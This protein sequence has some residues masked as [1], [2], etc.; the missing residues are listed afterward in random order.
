[1]SEKENLAPDEA[2]KGQIIG[3]MRK[4]KL[5]LYAAAKKLGI[6]KQQVNQWL[7]KDEWFRLCARHERVLETTELLLKI[8]ELRHVERPLTD[9]EQAIV[10]LTNPLFENRTRTARP[11]LLAVKALVIRAQFT[12]PAANAE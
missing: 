12:S 4:E 8:L 6:V 11:R 1:M 9:R 2:I 10:D 5:G 3:L 7:Y